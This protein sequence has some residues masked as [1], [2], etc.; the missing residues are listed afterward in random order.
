MK[1]LFITNL[2]PPQ[3]I[4]GYELR[5]KETA[6]E[7]S[8]RGHHVLVLTSRQ[9][10][11]NYRV[12]GNVHRLL[13][14]NPLGDVRKSE[15]IN[16]FWLRKR[17]YQLLGVLYNRRNYKITFELLNSVKPDLVFIWN[18][19]SIGV[20][21][22]IACQT[23][24]I[25]TVFSIGDY[26]LLDIK[27]RLSDMTNP[28]KRKYQAVI[29]GLGDFSQLDTRHILA[30]STSHKQIFVENGFL[31][32]NI[33]VIP[34]GV[35]SKTILPVGLL[36]NIP[37]N[38]DSKVMLLF[39]GRLVPE[40]AP[41]VAIRAL[42][43]LRKSYGVDNI[44]LDIIG[45]GTSEY[46]STLKNMVS[47]LRLEQ[48]VNFMGHIEH[49]SVLDLYSHYTVLLFPSRWSE[50]LGA[51]ILEA[52]ARGLLI[53]ASKRGG[54]LDVIRDEEN[55]LLVPVDDTGKMA[56]AI[57]RIIQ[58]PGLAHKL[59]LAALKTIHEEYRLEK[60]VDRMTEYFQHILNENNPGVSNEI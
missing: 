18:T 37:H 59:R 60:I 35:R 57:Y 6:D 42:A 32:Q 27:L 21:P 22:I 9:P 52:M 55:G 53:I 8:K 11:E 45:E 10:R 39:V 2:Y 12:I 4:G 24:G 48:A 44:F 17:Y 38:N 50:P 46:V 25:P 58:N 5:C 40:K 16:S 41:D 28:I 14:Y 34:R 19:S 20:L 54:P 31:E 7:L 23:Q 26:S 29:T 51:T 56:E 36:N 15:T 47:D 1:I 30:V 13:L 49:S 3:Y 33:N 43:I